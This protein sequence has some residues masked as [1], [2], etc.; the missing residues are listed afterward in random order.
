ME[1]GRLGE[2]AIFTGETFFLFLHLKKRPVCSLG[3]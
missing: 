3:F 2:A 1:K